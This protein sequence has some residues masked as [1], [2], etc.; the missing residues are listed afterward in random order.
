M[1]ALHHLQK[2]T[3][4][5]NRNGDKA[6][7]AVSSITEALLYL[8]QSSSPEAVEHAQRS[9]GAARMHQL[10][11]DLREVPQI[12]ILMQMIDICC[13]LLEYD[14]GQA[15]QK[16]QSMQKAM[17]QNIDDPRWNKDG[18]FSVPLKCA[19][20]TESGDIFYRQNGRMTLK[21]SWLSDHDL[22]A[23]CYFLSSVTISARNCFD[24]HKAEKYLSEGLRM[25]QSKFL[26][27]HE[28]V[29]IS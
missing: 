27:T 21:L 8:Q 28:I 23:L 18:S 13:S 26:Q 4:A 24:G 3:S 15:S 17:D 10:D 19:A 16:L 14:L 6:I 12:D 1:A 20:P 2:L 29:A 22:F 11:P 9:I 5:A 7:S 25:V